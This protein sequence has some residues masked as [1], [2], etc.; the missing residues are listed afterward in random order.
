MN[1]SR[2]ILFYTAKSV[3]YILIAVLLFA[4]FYNF[5]N[6]FYIGKAIRLNLTGEELG[7]RPLEVYYIY[8]DKDKFNPDWMSGYDSGNTHKYSFNGS[9]IV[10]DDGVKYVMVQLGDN[11]N[12]KAVIKS[13]SYSDSNGY[14]D[15]TYDDVIK[16]STNDMRLSRCEDGSI[17]AE[18]TGA[19]PYFVFPV[20]KLTP[21]KNLS[22]P[23]ALAAALIA[24]FIL[25][26]YIRIKSVVSM[27]ADLYGNRRLI[28]SLAVNDFK[29][30][31]A[32][33]Y[34]GIIWAFVQPVCTIMVF[35]FVFQIGFRSS[36]ID[37]VPFILWF[38]S[39]LIPW[40]FF[41]DAWNSATMALIEYS[42]LV[43]KVVFKVHI[44]PLVKIISSLFV[45]LF[46]IAFMVAFYL[47]YGVK[48]SLYWVQVLYYSVCMICLVVALSYITSALVVFFK[49]LGQIMNIILQ[50]GMW[51]TPIMWDIDRIPSNLM[52][53]FKLNPMYY[54]VQGYRE[55]MIYDI[56]F[57]NN[58]KQTL[59]FW[60]ILSVLMLMGCVIYKKLKPHF[61]DVL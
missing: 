41:S 5:F 56:P 22:I 51:L 2:T 7:A 57:W 23:F 46:F 14:T 35:W 47:I 28:M 50:F 44:L 30:R 59:Y 40:F 32:G 45:H 15:I 26:R 33:S 38:M 13:I 1:K 25:N 6:A 9:V 54:V 42:Y 58:I 61:A 55:S 34:F 12:A 27:A 49:D 17:S 37:D 20:P 36:D 60:M 18:A 31:Y 8:N 39:G 10:P 24:T 43:K 48:P 29:T 11:A 16:G 19:D 3:C 21:H 4:L 52:W 53:L